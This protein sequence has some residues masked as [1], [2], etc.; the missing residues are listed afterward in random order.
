MADDYKEPEDSP[1]NQADRQKQG[2]KP[3]QDSL[4]KGDNLNVLDAIGRK[5]KKLNP[6][7]DD[8]K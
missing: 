7:S 5:L 4:K 2:Y 8:E 3:F 6:F 1:A